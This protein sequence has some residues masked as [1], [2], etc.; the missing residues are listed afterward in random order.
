MDPI[1]PIGNESSTT[2]T[3]AKKNGRGERRRR[4][5]M[6][7]ADVRY[8]LPKTGT[9]LEHPELGREIPSENEALLESFRSSQPFYTLVAWKAVPE[10]EEGAPKI[11]KEALKRS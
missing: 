7:P 11:V 3:T 4:W 2:S 10:M 1:R 9:S 5:E 6:S 8:F